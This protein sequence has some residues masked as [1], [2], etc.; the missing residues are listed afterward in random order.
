MHRRITLLRRF[1][2]QVNINLFE[3]NIRVVG[4]LLGAF[5]L[6]GDRMFLHKAADLAER[7]LVAFNTYVL[8]AF[9][10]HVRVCTIFVTIPVCFV[11]VYT[12]VSMCYAVVGSATLAGKASLPCFADS[13]FS[14][15]RPNLCLQAL[16]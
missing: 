7:L 13:F 4:G 1:D 15:T 11:V 16:L 14:E 3:T 5:E 12:C 9:H 8:A 6:S 10:L 2:H